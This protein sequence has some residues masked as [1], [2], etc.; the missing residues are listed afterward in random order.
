MGK[1]FYSVRRGYKCG[2]YESW[3]ECKKQIEGYS[4]AVYKSFKTFEEAEVFLNSGTLF[5]EENLKTDIIAYVD[6]SYNNLTKEFSYGMVILNGEDEKHFCE[7]FY[8]EEL[9]EMRN[10]AGE[11]RGS[12]KAM[13]YCLEN[14]Y[15]S[16]LIYFDY[17]GIEKWC[18]GSWKTNKTGTR[19]YKT[20]YD[21]VKWKID[22]FFRKVKA[23]SGNK[24]NEIADKLAKEA[25]K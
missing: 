16:I 19:D 25:L 3:D 1:K 21:S 17:E 11:I 18:D 4:G 22:I 9:S 20:F 23:H 12:V 7:K 6:G 14:G 10:V 15:K 2:I 8:D 5:N 13:E 24:Y